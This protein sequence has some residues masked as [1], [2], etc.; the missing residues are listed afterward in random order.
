MSNTGLTSKQ[1][2]AHL[3]EENAAKG[4][5]QAASLAALLH[6]LL[7]LEEERYERAH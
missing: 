3:S 6:D 4:D 1:I 2:A 5:R 7:D